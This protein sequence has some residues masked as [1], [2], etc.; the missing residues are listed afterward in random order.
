VGLLVG[1]VAEAMMRR[2]GAPV[3]MTRSAGTAIGRE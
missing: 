2:A 1:S 3:F